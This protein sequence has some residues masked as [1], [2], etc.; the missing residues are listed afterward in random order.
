M[1]PRLPI[2]D[3][4]PPERLEHFT[5]KVTRQSIIYFFGSPL[6]VC[7]CLTSVYV[8]VPFT[9]LA[10]IKLSCFC[11]SVLIFYFAA[12]LFLFSG[13]FAIMLLLNSTY[14]Y[15]YFQ[16][17]VETGL[18][19]EPGILSYR[20]RRDRTSDWDR[21]LTCW[22]A[23]QVNPSHL[24]MGSAKI[25]THL[26]RTQIWRPNLIIS[27]NTCRPIFNNIIFRIIF[28]CH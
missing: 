20:I 17:R 6:R 14:Y 11:G 15:Y 18:L 26:S 1:N 22:N 2:S 27:A 10:N 7:E 9:H 4:P 21:W 25:S 3:L 5:F 28:H 12:L 16:Q 19:S 8:C 23:E 13:Q 24:S